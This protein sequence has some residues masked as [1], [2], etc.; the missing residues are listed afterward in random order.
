MFFASNICC[1]SSATDRPRYCCE[2]RLVRGAKPIMKKCRRGNGTRFTASL[3]R[4]EFSWPGKRRQHVT[5]DIT[6]ATRWFRSPNVGVVSF[7]VRKQIS[8]RASLSMHIDSSEFSTSWC[9]D[10]VVLYGSTTVSDTRGDGMTEK[11]I[12]MRSGYSSRSFE[13]SSVPIPE[14][15][16]PPRECDSWKP[17]RQSQLSASLRHTSSTESISSAPSV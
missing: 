14:P 15:V 7:S 1:V 9:T 16:P 5:P 17:C 4:S 3:R 10:S 13:I 6:A 12:M 2:P 11:V 8:Y